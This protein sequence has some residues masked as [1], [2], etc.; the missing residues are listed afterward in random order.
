MEV[1][2]PPGGFIYPRM[3]NETEFYD[4]K[5]LGEENL[6][7]AIVGLAVDHLTRWVMG[8]SLLP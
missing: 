8:F 5:T 6:P 1:D 2:Q 7:P 3:L 4:G